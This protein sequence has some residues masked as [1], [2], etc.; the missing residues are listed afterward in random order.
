MSTP[1]SKADAFCSARA[2]LTLTDAVE[3]IFLHR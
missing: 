2:S 3:K 1:R